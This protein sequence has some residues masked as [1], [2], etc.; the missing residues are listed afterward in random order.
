MVVQRVRDSSG[1]PFAR[2]EQKIAAY[3]PTPSLH[4]IKRVGMY[5]R[6]GTPLN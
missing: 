3:S 4:Q 2:H 1:N 6:G 5:M